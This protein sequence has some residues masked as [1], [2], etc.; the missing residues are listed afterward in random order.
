MIT[1]ELL[2]LMGIFFM[3]GH[4]EKCCAGPNPRHYACTISWA[5]SNQKK[6]CE[7]LRVSFF[8][9]EFFS[10]CAAASAF[11]MRN[12]VRL[13]LCGCPPSYVRAR[14]AG[15]VRTVTLRAL[16]FTVLTVQPAI[17]RATG[18]LW[19]PAECSACPRGRNGKNGNSE[20]PQLYRSYRSVH[21]NCVKK[22][23]LRMIT[24]ELLPLMGNFFYGRTRGKVLC[25]P[26]PPALCVHDFMGPI[27]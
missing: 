12:A 7:S 17:L 10:A 21:H 22:W 2:P 13:A 16:N 6:T 4:V 26:E 25:W 18:L 19:A 9:N 24:P 11:R 8:K 23:W 27:E 5:Q 20:G 1:P 3:V 15:T 14:E